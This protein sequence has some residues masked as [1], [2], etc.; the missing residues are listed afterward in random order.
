MT[1]YNIRT[2][3]KAGTN[4]SFNKRF[5][6]AVQTKFKK[7]SEEFKKQIRPVVIEILRN[8]LYS[9]PEYTSVVYGKLRGEFG[10]VDP[11]EKMDVIIDHII[12]R[13]LVIGTNIEKTG[14]KI[15]IQ[16]SLNFKV[17][18]GSLLSISEAF[19]LTEKGSV[20]PWL[21]WLI[22]GR[23]QEGV[24]GFEIDNKSPT[25]GR[26]GLPYRMV[27]S[28]NS[29]IPGSEDSSSVGTIDDNYIT[30]ALNSARTKMQVKIRREIQKAIK[31]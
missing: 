14:G 22:A 23:G 12:N 21:Y 7:A 16:F 24:Q 29:Y 30:R 26:S 11:E 8:E 20:L 15:H 9:A 27:K 31:Q 6:K 28:N 10:L 19:Q 13:V 5:T 1:R 18:Y 2:S 3:F 17:D 4:I 25:I